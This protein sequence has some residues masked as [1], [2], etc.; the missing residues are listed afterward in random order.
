MPADLDVH[1]IWDNYATHK[2]AMIRDWLA[3]RPRRNV[4]LTPTSSSWLNQV[5][6]F[7]ALLTDK[8]IRR[9]V[10]W[11]VGELE[12]AINPFLDQ[13][14]ADQSPSGGSGP[15]MTS[16]LPSSASALITL[17]RHDMT[18]LWFRTRTAPASDPRSTDT[19][20][21]RFAAAGLFV[22]RTAFRRDCTVRDRTVPSYVYVLLNIY[23]WVTV[24]RTNIDIDDDL[25][26]A[27]MR[28]TGQTT[29]RGTVE[30]A[31]RRVVTSYRRRQAIADMA[32]AGLA[33]WRLCTPG[34]R[35]DRRRYI[36][37]DLPP[38]RSSVARRAPAA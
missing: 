22:I 8:Q 17:H 33:T 37:V 11:S 12:A 28:A 7:F 13:H 36:G 14:N 19:A 30:E 10:H 23:T 34:N 31:L 3:K 29:K 2:T 4:H 5:E 18:D 20:A 9:G 24:M 25:I 35:G 38:A 21:A 15:P 6:R 16:S 27:A 26:E 1:L 32:G